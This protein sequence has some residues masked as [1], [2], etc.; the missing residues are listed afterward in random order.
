MTT[1]SHPSREIDG[2]GRSVREWLAGRRPAERI[3][4]PERQAE[5]AAS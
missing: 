2:K 4:N 5:E 1:T 3:W